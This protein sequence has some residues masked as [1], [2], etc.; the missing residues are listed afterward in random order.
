MQV[1]RWEFEYEQERDVQAFFGNIENIE[2]L[3]L[4]N[5]TELEICKQGRNH[6]SDYDITFFYKVTMLKIFFI[7]SIKTLLYLISLSIISFYVQK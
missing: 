6:L 1:L 4:M 5:K 2:K 3:K 7:A